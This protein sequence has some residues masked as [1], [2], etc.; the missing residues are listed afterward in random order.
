MN[1]SQRM[2]PQSDLITPLS[3]VFPNL[4]FYVGHFFMMQ[5]QTRLSGFVTSFSIKYYS[6]MHKKRFSHPP[7][8]SLDYPSMVEDIYILGLFFLACDINLLSSGAGFCACMTSSSCQN[9]SSR[10]AQNSI[11]CQHY[12]S[13]GL[14]VW[15]T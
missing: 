2:L 6:E 3:L 14:L 12:S 15:A 8:L 11:L 9:L 7:I 4:S 10:V 5:Q 1:F 13:E